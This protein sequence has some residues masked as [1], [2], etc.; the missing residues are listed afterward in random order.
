MS[1]LQEEQSIA[2]QS[3]KEFINELRTS[4]AWNNNPSIAGPT[5]MLP[6]KGH[7]QNDQSSFTVNVSVANSYSNLEGRQNKEFVAKKNTRSSSTSTDQPRATTAKL[8][9]RLGHL[10]AA[11]AEAHHASTSLMSGVDRTNS[12]KGLGTKSEPRHVRS[13]AWV[14]ADSSI[15]VHTCSKCDR[16]YSNRG[17]L[18]HHQAICTS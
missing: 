4:E 15:E 9:G 17:E 6:N 12:S 11:I 1:Q 16:M 18:E 3:S 5:A 10:V 14:S 8:K 13:N 7:Q 2:R